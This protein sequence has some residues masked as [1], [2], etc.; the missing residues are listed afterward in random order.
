M[1]EVSDWIYCRLVDRGSFIFPRR[2]FWLGQVE[3]SDN[4]KEDAACGAALAESMSAFAVS[5]TG[6]GWEQLVRARLLMPR[7]EA[8]DARKF[9]AFH[10]AETLQAFN[11][12]LSIGMSELR[13]TEAGYLYNIRRRT[14]SPLMPPWRGRE[15]KGISAMMDEVAQHPLHV[16]NTLFVAPKAYGELGDAFRRSSHWRDLAERAE[17]EG[18]ALLLYWMSAE[19]LC[20]QHHDEAIGPKLLAACG[21]P[22]GRI[23]RGLDRRVI[24]QLSS[25]PGHRSWCKQ[26]ASLFEGLRMARNKIVHAGYRHVDLPQI[27]TQERRSL[28]MFVLPLATKCLSELALQALNHR[29]TTFASMWEKYGSLLEPLGVVRHAAWFIERLESSDASRR[30]TWGERRA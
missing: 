8:D 20:K 27:L 19:C 10:L 14:V 4:G 23:A 17:D 25:I 22:V 24:S 11:A 15:I 2:P 28:G 12:H 5:E 16:I 9:G 26:L 18:E 21:F 3:F 13:A 30:R 7:V 6:E 29:N 1:S